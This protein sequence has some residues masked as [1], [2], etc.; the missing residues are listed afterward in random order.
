M[1]LWGIPSNLFPRPNQWDDFVETSK[2]EPDEKGK[3]SSDECPKSGNPVV[4]RT[5]TKIETEVD[6]TGGG[7]M[8]LTL[9]RTFNSAAMERFNIFD[10]WYSNLD[11]QLIVYTD[12]NQARMRR[13]DGRYLVFKRG[14]DGVYREDGAQQGGYLSS[15][16]GGKWIYVSPDLTTETYA[17][18]K[19]VEI[20]NANGVRWTLSYGGPEESQLQRVT[21]SNGRYIEFTWTQKN[22]QTGVGP[23]II[24]VR[25][26]Q[27]N[28]IEYGYT[29]DAYGFLESVTYAGS[30]ATTVKYHYLYK[31]LGQ[32]NGIPLLTGKSINGSRYSMFTYDQQQRATSTAHSG[33]V[34][35]FG[36]AYEQGSNGESVTVETNPLGKVAR[37][38][39]KDRRLIAIEGLPSANCAAG[40]SETHYDENGNKSLTLDFEGNLT[41]YQ[42]D[43]H[44]H[45]LL[46]EEASGTPVART[47][48][49]E[50][51]E[52]N[53]RLAAET[54]QGV[55]ETRYSY[56]SNNRLTTRSQK[57][58]VSGNA[59]GEVQ[60]TTFSYQLHSNG[61][62]SRMV[63]DGPAAGNGDAVTFTYSDMGDL[64][65]IENSMGHAIVMGDYTNY[66]YPGYS[67]DVNGVRT[68]FVYDSRGRPSEVR[69]VL[70]NGTRTTQ[71]EYDAF[72][73]LASVTGPDGVRISNL[74]DVAGRLI[75]TSIPEPGGSFAETR[76]TYNALSLP[77]SETIQRVYADP[78]RGTQP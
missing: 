7:E 2:G 24:R 75:S 14:G 11:R 17:D 77:T 12:S 34:E 63:E 1:A 36:F 78:G 25:D 21:H 35:R 3:D 64:T 73:K 59:Q 22:T 33:G 18:S 50:W 72:G 5:G 48:T 52:Q 30:P 56:D 54:L 42:Y 66:G 16:A 57:S 51:D 49:F 20:R 9:E 46:R 61:L 10:S 38:R 71:Y 23:R 47:T 26:P 68:N 67:I 4:V 53:N 58:L 65:R 37:Y 31:E 62:V 70:P 8:P 32:S 55:L 40:Y 19:M 28:V 69:L 15:A 41:R 60:T 44:G 27:G 6:F 74:Y 29:Q 39:F 76:Y 13:P 45:L 43:G